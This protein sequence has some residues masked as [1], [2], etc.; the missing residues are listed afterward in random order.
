MKQREFDL[1]RV[2]LIVFTIIYVVSPIDLMPGVPI[3]DMALIVL[4]VY[5]NRTVTAKIEG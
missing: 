5:L 4:N 3:D 1:K 2:L